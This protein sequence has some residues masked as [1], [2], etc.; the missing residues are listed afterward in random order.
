MKSLENITIKEK[1]VLLRVDLNIPTK[2]GLVTDKT[3][4]NVIKPTINYL[5][6]N[7]TR[8]QIVKN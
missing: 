7:K 1:N 3:R 5:R 2:N 8:D 6:K 4:I